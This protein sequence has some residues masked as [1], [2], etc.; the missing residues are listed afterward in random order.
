MEELYIKSYKLQ[1]KPRFKLKH[2]N[3]ENPQKNYKGGIL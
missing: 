3:T 1:F 2:T